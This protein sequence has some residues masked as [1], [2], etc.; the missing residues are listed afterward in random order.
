M[1]VLVVVASDLPN[2]RANAVQQVRTAAA[3]SRLGLDVCIVAKQSGAPVPAS[4]VFR[5]Y[6]ITPGQAPHLEL[7]RVRPGRQRYRAFFGRLLLRRE[8]WQPRLLLTREPRVVVMSRLTRPRRRVIFEAHDLGDLPGRV[9]N[10]RGPRLQRLAL[11]LADGVV[12]V[13][14]AG[15]SR[16]RAAGV[17]PDRLVVAPDAADTVAG[18]DPHRGFSSPARIVYVGSLYDDR[19]CDLLI[20]MLGRVDGAVLTVV[21]GPADRLPAL[22][23][24]AEARGVTR[25]VSL[26]P[27]VPHADV[28][29]ILVGADILALPMRPGPVGDVF[30]SPMKLFEYMA[31]G[32]PIVAADLPTLREIVDDRHVFFFRPGSATAL[33]QKVEEVLADPAEARRRAACALELLETRHTYEERGR[34]IRDFAEVRAV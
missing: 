21:G 10:R 29:G 12:T 27:P 24:L 4:A 7:I 25:R 6:G 22:R 13:T 16:L 32:R 33:A 17:G 9:S 14:N 19:G 8:W 3:L 31:A 15:A 23:A 26:R 30:A 2:E 1:N 5:H 28:P 20:E 18:A 11:R 34:R